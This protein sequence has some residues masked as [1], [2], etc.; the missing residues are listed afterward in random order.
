M[1]DPKDGVATKL[2]L[3]PNEGVLDCPN[4]APLLLVCPNVKE[5]AVAT[6]LKGLPLNTGVAVGSPKRG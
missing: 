4:I 3:C 2:E 6:L 1:V 5:L